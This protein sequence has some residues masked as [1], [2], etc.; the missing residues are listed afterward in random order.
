METLHSFKAV[1]CHETIVK[2]PFLF[3]L[4]LTDLIKLKTACQFP[5]N[6]LLRIIKVGIYKSIFSPLLLNQLNSYL[7][8]SRMSLLQIQLLLSHI[9]SKIFEITT[10]LV[11]N[12]ILKKYVRAITSAPINGHRVYNDLSKREFYKTTPVIV[13]TYKILDGV[14]SNGVP[15]KRTL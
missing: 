11:N 13:Y 14:T 9:S 12:N 7:L 5:R 2:P 10:A 8:K 6:S 15:C 1:H 3:D 4:K